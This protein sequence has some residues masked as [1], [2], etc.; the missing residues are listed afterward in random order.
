MFQCFKTH[1][2][3]STWVGPNKRKR[4]TLLAEGRNYYKCIIT[5]TSQDVP[6]DTSHI[7]L[8]KYTRIYNFAL[9]TC[10]IASMCINEHQNYVLACMIPGV[11][12]VRY[13]CN[14]LYRGFQVS[15]HVY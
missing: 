5:N 7:I 10:V 6:R 9:L 15:K 8:M 14:F 12:V 13:T 1:L 3:E 2:F 11:N 4:A